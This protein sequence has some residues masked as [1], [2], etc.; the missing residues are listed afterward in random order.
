V[1]ELSID[2]NLKHPFSDSISSSSYWR[3]RIEQTWKVL[4]GEAD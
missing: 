3:H 1:C 4:G 2:F